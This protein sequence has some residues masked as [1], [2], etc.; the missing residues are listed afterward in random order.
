MI[1]DLDSL[2]KNQREAV[3]WN[4]GPLLVLAGP[5]SGKTRVLTMRVAKL[6]LDSPDKRFRVLGLTF[7]NKAAAEMRTR[8]D[9]MVSEGR[10]R[11]LLTTFHSFSAE[12]LRQHGSHCGIRPDFVILNE[13]ADR[14]GYLLDA[15][16]I[17][18]RKGIDVSESD[19][20]F[21]PLIDKLLEN[22]ATEDQVEA[23]V[24]DERIG[25]KV[26]KIYGAY[27]GQLRESNR[28]DFPSLLYC[29]HEVL[30]SAEGVAEQIRMV[31]THVCVDEFQDTNL[32]QY[33]LL[34]ELVGEEP[35]NLF[36]V[37]DDDQIIYQWNGASPE[38]LKELRKDYDMKVIQLPANYRCPADVIVLANALIRNNI[39]RAA[40]KSPLYAAKGPS[41][42]RVVRVMAFDSLNDE[43]GKVAVDIL[44][45]PAEER[46]RCVILA[47]ANKLLGFA[48]QSLERAG[49]RA[50]LLVR[51]SEFGS[52]PFKWLHAVLRLAN[53]R[54]DMEQLRRVCKCFYE[55]RGID[56]EVEE[57]IAYASALAG[58]YLRSW[59]ERA[60]RRTEG[61]PETHNFLLSARDLIVDR[62]DFQG[63]IRSAMTWFETALDS[64]VDEA[65]DV[66]ADFKDEK[67]IWTELQKQV[68]EKY[69]PEEV[70]LQVLLQEFDLT[71]KLPPV[72]HDAIRCLTIA[73]SKGL[74]FGHVYLVG[75]VEDQL[76]SFH[77]VKKGPLSRE[78]QEERRNCFVAITRSESTLTLTY[79]RSYFGWPKEPSRFLREMDLVD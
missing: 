68:F 10:E 16:K 71:P 15:I 62:L 30:S 36:V 77:S 44:A 73:S 55:L 69:G 58:D 6:L 41:K 40:D 52:V 32:A 60:I 26:A 66:F 21:L 34:R 4:G 22:F 79:A 64:A 33:R 23:L 24:A 61:E 53:A 49:L 59:M 13:D 54:G 8:V 47:R 78:M 14:E 72:A 25:P 11:V 9:E 75:M 76:P 43:V 74:E 29:T 3:T 70:T 2:N 56:I 65:Q 50:S 67:V 39:D 27:R 31:Y 51:K 42:G 38:R 28:L 63:L 7:T 19:L 5:G 45:R 46:S 48:A 18:Q 35:A 1:F 37:A 17:L 57:V 20:R 12:I